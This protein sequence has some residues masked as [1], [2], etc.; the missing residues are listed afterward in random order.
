MLSRSFFMSTKRTVCFLNSFWAKANLAADKELQLLSIS[1]VFSNLCSLENH[2]YNSHLQTG[3]FLKTYLLKCLPCKS[4]V[5][6]YSYLYYREIWNCFILLCTSL[7]T[8]TEK[9]TWQSRENK[10]KKTI[11][12]QKV[13]YWYRTISESLTLQKLEFSQVRRKIK[14]VRNP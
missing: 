13:R 5:S 3:N 11:L 8:V 9:N 14:K 2:K 4:C 12:P 1:L 6:V 7:Y 10:R